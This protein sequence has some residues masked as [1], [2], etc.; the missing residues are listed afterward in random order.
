[1]N[2]Y[3]FKYGSCS[4]VIGKYIYNKYLA[5]KENK[6]VKV[7][8]LDPN[9]DEFVYLDEIRKIE[10]YSSYYCLPDSDVHIIRP[11]NEFYKYLEQ[12]FVSE[13]PKNASPLVLIDIITLD[14]SST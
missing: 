4:I 1:M 6:L 3:S 7:I 14:R 13:N 10:N 2:D 8:K 12:Y 11:E 5:E 9:H